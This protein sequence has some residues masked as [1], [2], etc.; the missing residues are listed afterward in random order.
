MCVTA[1]GKMKAVC[2]SPILVKGNSSVRCRTA[3][4]AAALSQLRDVSLSFVREIIIIEMIKIKNKIKPQ[5]LF[6]FSQSR[7]A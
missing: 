3:H 1:E 7:E 2:I 5:F 6:S 4:S